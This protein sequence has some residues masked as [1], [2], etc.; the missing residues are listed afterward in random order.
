VGDDGTVKMR[1]EEVDGRVG[2]G[3]GSGGGGG[4]V[5]GEGGTC[6]NASVTNCGTSEQ[7]SVL[8]WFKTRQHA[9]PPSKGSTAFVVTPHG[10]PTSIAH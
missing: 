1:R 3:G 9:S 8:R 7:S 10:D 5:C 2:E 4:G 6:N